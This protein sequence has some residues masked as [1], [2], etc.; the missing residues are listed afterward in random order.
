MSFFGYCIL[1]V[2]VC[3]LANNHA[4]SSNEALI[5]LSVDQSQNSGAID[6]TNIEISVY[7]NQEDDCDC[8]DCDCTGNISFIRI[9]E[10]TGNCYNWLLSD[11]INLRRCVAKMLRKIKLI[12]RLFCDLLQ[13]Y[14]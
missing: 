11:F 7:S 12:L 8:E 4:E 2:V 14:Y 6:E 9:K 13:L 10:R 3:L 5:N 1:F